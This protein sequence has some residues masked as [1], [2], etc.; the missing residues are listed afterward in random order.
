MDLW[1]ASG[2]RALVQALL[3]TWRARRV[4]ASRLAAPTAARDLT[5]VSVPRL[6]G[7]LADEGA[8]RGPRRGQ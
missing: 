4:W 1:P 3:M 8:N 7:L 2:L 5:A 6:E